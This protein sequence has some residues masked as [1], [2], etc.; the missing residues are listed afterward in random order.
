MP[1]LLLLESVSCN[2]ERS[3]QNE[4]KTKPAFKCAGVFVLL[5]Y[6]PHINTQHSLQHH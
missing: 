1:H 3:K 2:F 5:V 4:I 6:M